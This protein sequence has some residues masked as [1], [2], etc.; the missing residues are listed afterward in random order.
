MNYEAFTSTPE[1]NNLHPVKQQIIRE[2]M[3]TN[4]HT[5]PEV[6]LPRLL[7]IDKELSKRNLSF[8]KEETTLLINIIKANMTPAEQQKVD[9]LMGLFNR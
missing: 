6:M 9:M 1:F 2:V 5:S 8:T 3:Q 7:S 4:T